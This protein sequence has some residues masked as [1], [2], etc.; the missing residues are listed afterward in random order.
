MTAL[1][2]RQHP[3]PG[4]RPGVAVRFVTAK[5]GPDE[6]AILNMAEILS[7]LGLDPAEEDL[8]AGIAWR[9]IGGGWFVPVTVEPE[10]PHG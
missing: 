1:G 6:G 4:F 10:R 3:T 8:L 9:A 7:R 5:N 2:Q